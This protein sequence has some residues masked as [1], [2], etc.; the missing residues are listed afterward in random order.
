MILDFDGSN[1]PSVARFFSGFGASPEVYQAIGF[2]RFPFTLL[3]T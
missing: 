1:I 3:K 2:R